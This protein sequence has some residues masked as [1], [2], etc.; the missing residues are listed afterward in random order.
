M[1]LPF[2]S[3]EL[4]P[5]FLNSV[6]KSG[7]HLLKQALQG[8][9][10]I[11]HDPKNELYEGYLNQIDN[12]R[13]ILSELKPNEFAA[14]H[15]YFSTEWA[16][17]IQTLN[18]KQ[19]FIYR[20]PRDVV[21]SYVHFI[22]DKYPYHPLYPYLQKLPTDKERF[23]T[24][25]NGVEFNGLKY[26]N[27]KDWYNRFV[28]WH[29]TKN[30]LSIRYED[31]VN[32]DLQRKNTF[33][34]IMEFLWEDMQPPVSIRIM[35]QSMERNSDPK[36]SFTFRSGKTGNWQQEFDQEVKEAFKSVAGQVLID[37]GYEENLDW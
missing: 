1:F 8:I 18:M 4:P 17:M 23:L 14:G 27:I 36:K 9:P 19:I 34:T 10:Q 28:G 13:K 37:L 20:D 11:K 32:N 25:I 29:I 33:K 6:P 22:M 35:I 7:T 31:L 26:P 2:L 16:K 3:D 5:F 15:I 21:I 30:T 24:F 12:H